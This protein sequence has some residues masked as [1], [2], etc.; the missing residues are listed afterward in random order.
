MKRVVM[1]GLLAIGIVGC[2]GSDSNAPPPDPH[3]TAAGVYYLVAYNNALPPQTIFTN[4]AGRVEVS[5]GNM[6]LRADK[7]YTENLTLR[8]VFNSGAPPETSQA[9]ENGTFAIVGTQI[10]FTLPVSGTTPSVSYTGAISGDVLS[11]TLNGA[12]YRYQR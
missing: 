3:V 2:K 10:T 4:A 11:Y 12:S 5:G 6:V 8:I 7:S 1:V 9:V